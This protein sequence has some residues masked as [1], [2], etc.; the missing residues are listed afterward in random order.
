MSISGV[1]WRPTYGA[2]ER[3]LEPVTLVTPL[4]DG[5]RQPIRGKIEGVRSAE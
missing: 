2:A 1:F 3:R 5:T 4:L